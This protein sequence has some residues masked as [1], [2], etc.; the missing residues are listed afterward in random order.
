MDK[1]KTIRIKNI[2]GEKDEYYIS[3]EGEIFRKLKTHPS[4]NGYLDFKFGAGGKHRRV[5]RMVA[6]AFVPN[7][8][9][10]PEVNH[11]DRNIY[12][13][14][15]SNLEWVTGKENIQHMYNNGDSPVR[16]AIYC[17]LYK[18]DK[19]IDSFES[20]TDAAEYSNKHWG[21]SIESLKR[22]KYNKKLGIIIKEVK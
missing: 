6:T 16:N 10:K 21:A 5:H 19:L 18:N 4:S 7:P 8:N 1:I 14:H 12:N 11:I 22:Y 13:N 9:N 2:E 15:Y 3:D 17:E 20:I